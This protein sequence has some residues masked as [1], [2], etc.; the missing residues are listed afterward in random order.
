MKDLIP[1]E[2]RSKDLILR[3]PLLVALL[4]TI[5]IEVNLALLGLNPIVDIIETQPLKAI[6]LFGV[7]YLFMVASAYTYIYYYRS[8]KL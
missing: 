1:K 5:F 7:K 8:R 6:M 3:R 4:A 2:W